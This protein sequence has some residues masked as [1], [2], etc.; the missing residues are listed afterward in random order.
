MLIIFSVVQVSIFVIL[1]EK[2]IILT[3][4]FQLE[5]IFVIELKSNV[6]IKTF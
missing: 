5:N 4:Q 1:L 3:I 2:L 6:P